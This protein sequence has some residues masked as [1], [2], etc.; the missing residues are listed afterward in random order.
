MKRI[1]FIGIVLASVQ[2]LNAQSSK[3]YILEINGDTIHISLD[4][5][6]N[7]K[8]SGGQNYKVKLSKKELANYSNE[9]IS[10]DYPSQL[11]VTAKKIEEDIEQL[12]L[13]TALGNGIIIQV[14][15]SINPEMAID[16]MLSQ[17]TEDDISAGYK[18]TITET[19]KT[20]GDGS[21]LKGKRAV[22]TLEKE[23]EE[24]VCVANGKRKKGVLI[25]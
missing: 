2:M 6:V 3:N 22:L 23:T 9:Y 18:Q 1:F 5:Q 17:V 19:Q 12:L 8:A 20:I 21:V 11:T 14:Y 15:S 10:F 7:F 25:E 24:F 4:E 16:F 13:L